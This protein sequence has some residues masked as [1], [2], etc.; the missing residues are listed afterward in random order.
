[1]KPRDSLMSFWHNTKASLKTILI[2]KFELQY[3]AKV[4][5]LEQF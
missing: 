2:L 5:Q 4:L 1:M 3:F